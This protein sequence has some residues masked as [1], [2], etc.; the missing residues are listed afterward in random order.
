MKIHFIS[1]AASYNPDHLI[2]S[3]L[4]RIKC[5]AKNLNVFEFKL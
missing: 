4:S 3:A 2:Y 1:F 5:Q